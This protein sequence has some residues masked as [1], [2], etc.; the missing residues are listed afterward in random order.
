MATISDVQVIH[1]T[2]HDPEKTSVKR[3]IGLEGDV[4]RTRRPYPNAYIRVPQGH[5]WVEGDAADERLS[6]DSNTY[7]PI[8]VRLVTGRITHILLPSNKAGRVR[9]WEHR[10]RT[11]IVRA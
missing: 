1:R 5:I 6:I 3:V 9:W 2:P 4:I 10:D 7:G 11:G 8:S